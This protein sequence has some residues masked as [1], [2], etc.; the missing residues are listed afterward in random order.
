MAASKP[1]LEQRRREI[2]A[3]FRAT[4]GSYRVEPNNLGSRREMMGEY[5]K[6]F[7]RVRQEGDVEDAVDKIGE[8]ELEAFCDAIKEMPHQSNAVESGVAGQ[9]AGRGASWKELME[10]AGLQQ[11]RSVLG[12]L[13]SVP[14]ELGL[15]STPP[16]ELKQLRAEAQWR[17]RVLAEMLKVTERELE[18]LDTEIRAHHDLES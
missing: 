15:S 12:W 18:E 13:G 5:F 2:L 11:F 1:E 7:L 6:P 3:Q 4:R 8:A 10:G 14:L 16:A 17:Q 9:T